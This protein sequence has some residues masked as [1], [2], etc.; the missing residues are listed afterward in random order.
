MEPYTRSSYEQHAETCQPQRF[1]QRSTQPALVKLNDPPEEAAGRRLFGGQQLGQSFLFGGWGLIFEA[2]LANEVAA[3]GRS[4][5]QRQC[6]RSEQRNAHG[7]GERAK[8]S[9]G[10]AGDRH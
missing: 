3:E 4:P 8:E 1:F 6:K 10:D 7:Q 9:S 5:R 2:V